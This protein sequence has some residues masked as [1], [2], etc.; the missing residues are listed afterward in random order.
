[1]QNYHGRVPMVAGRDGFLRVF[2]K[3]S[4]PNHWMPPVRVRW[5]V[6]N[7]L[8]RTD[9]IA[10]PGA[11]VPMTIDEGTLNSSWNL[12]VPGA[13]FQPGLRIVA[14]V[15]PSNVIAESN[16]ANNSFS[17]DSVGEFSKCTDPAGTRDAG[18]D[19]HLRWAR[20]H[21][22]PLMSSRI[23]RSCRRST[24]CRV[25]WY[26]C[27]RPSASYR[28]RS[29]RRRE[30]FVARC[31]FGVVDR[32]VGG[33]CG[34]RRELLWR[35]RSA[36]RGRD[37]RARIRRL[38]GGDRQRS[39]HARAN[40]RARTRAQLGAHAFAVRKSGDSDPQYPYPSGNIGVYGYDVATIRCTR[41]R[42]PT[43]L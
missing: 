39:R 23:W 8:V 20:G 37:H 32:A 5:Y 21:V 14:D 34:R 16:E 22:M 1:M 31:A 17:T 11:S 3:A 15:D 18:A 2:V 43:T 7:T 24:R 4:R 30:P 28:L 6:E 27:T 35:G 10:A 19:P 33:E 40:A 9:T 41:P 13:L 38:S 12:F 25:T 36:V 42:W 26:R 29:A